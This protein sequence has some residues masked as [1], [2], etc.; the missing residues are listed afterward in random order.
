MVTFS[1]FWKMIFH[2]NVELIIMLCNLKEN[3]KAQCDLYWPHKEPGDFHEYPKN[4]D[5]KELKVTLLSETF[6]NDLYE[7]IFLLEV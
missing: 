4:A 6:D 5:S 7:R 1:N 3:N 2:E